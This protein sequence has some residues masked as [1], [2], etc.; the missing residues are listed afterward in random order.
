MIQTLNAILIESLLSSIYANGKLKICTNASPGV[1]LGGGSGPPSLQQDDPRDSHK[2]PDFWGES[3]G[4]AVNQ[5]LLIDISHMPSCA[6]TWAS[7]GY[8]SHA[9]PRRP[10]KLP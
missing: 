3:G 1:A 2:S 10:T 9:W 4:G 7:N 8:S 5:Q 6:E